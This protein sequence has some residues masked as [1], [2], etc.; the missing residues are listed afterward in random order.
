MTSLEP[1]ETERVVAAAG[2]VAANSAWYARRLAIS[3]FNVE[4]TFDRIPI[5]TETDLAAGYYG[6]DEQDGGSTFATSGTTS[7]SGRRVAWPAVDHRRYVGQR[8]SLFHSLL[9]DTCRTACADLGT[10]HAQASALEIFE[11]L[12]LEAYE[13]DVS[14]PIDRHVTVLR[15]RRPDLLYTMPVILERIVGAGGPGYVPRW[16]V[17]LGDMAPRSWRRAM[18]RRLGM[19]PGRIVDVF[20]S[21]EVGAIAYSDDEHGRYLF[22]EH[23]LPEAAAPG[24]PRP[25]GGQLL[26]L[27]STERCAFPAVRY[28]AG[29]LVS[30]LRPVVVAGRRRWAFDSHLGREGTM[31]KHGEA[32]SLPVMTERIAA[33]A[34]GVAWSVRRDG[35]EAVIEI[36]ERAYT[37]ALADAVRHAVREAHPAVD[38]MIVSGL[39]GD[40]RVEP[41]VFAVGSA[42]RWI[43]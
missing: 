13:I 21:I 14:E 27:T 23:I 33:V 19:R 11:R 20:G 38:A 18:E 1:D 9:G 17:V 8:A 32:L 10:G 41:R 5:L 7:G 39:V 4:P 6:S 25:D 29:D 40:L 34:P 24:R 43:R 12:G 35:L 42:K 16:I 28:A 36:D 26:V 31:V 15:S 3:G 30:G 37:P 2:R 22:H